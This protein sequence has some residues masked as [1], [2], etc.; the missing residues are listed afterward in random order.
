[1]QKTGL[2]GKLAEVLARVDRIPKNGHNSHFNYDYVMESDL[3]DQIRP[4]LAERK[5]VVLPSVEEATQNGSLSTLR[6]RFRFIDAESGDFEDIVF[7]GQGQD[8]GDKGYYKA[9]TGAVKYM[10]MKTFLVATGDDPDRDDNSGSRGKRTKAGDVG[11][12]KV[13]ER[14]DEP[15]TTRQ[16]DAIWALVGQTTSGDAETIAKTISEKFKGRLQ[17]AKEKSGA[18]EIQCSKTEA[19]KIIQEL[20]G[21]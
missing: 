9:Y 12:P 11:T 21:R 7:V 1:M 4:M 15:A 18:W 14:P 19:G 13:A 17:V 2:Y 3:V 16:T 8:T 5:I 10:L 20:Q 6:I